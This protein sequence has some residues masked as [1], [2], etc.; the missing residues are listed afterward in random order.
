MGKNTHVET[1]NNFSLRPAHA[2]SNEQYERQEE[3]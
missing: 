2:E 3:L 1:Y